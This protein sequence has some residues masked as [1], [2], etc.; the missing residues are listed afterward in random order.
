[1]TPGQTVGLLAE[2]G[3]DEAGVSV[4]RLCLLLRA[5]SC[6][7]PFSPAGCLADLH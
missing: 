3:D 4:A 7:P 5:F 1:M 2:A 6:T